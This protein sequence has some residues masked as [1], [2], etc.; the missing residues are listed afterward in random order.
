MDFLRHFAAR[1]SRKL[2]RAK[3]LPDDTRPASQVPDRKSR[4]SPDADQ[5]DGFPKDQGLSRAA[6]TQAILK[7]GPHHFHKLL[8]GLVSS[9]EAISAIFAFVASSSVL[10]RTIFVT[11]YMSP[12]G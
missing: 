1:F 6:G 5:H 11:T 8:R 2:S 7:L 3:L 4:H 12:A 10:G 9:A